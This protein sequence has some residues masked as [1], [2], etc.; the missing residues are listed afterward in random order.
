MQKGNPNYVRCYT[1]IRTLGKETI[2]KKK[3]KTETAHKKRVVTIN[4]G[5]FQIGEMVLKP[6]Q[7]TKPGR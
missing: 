2:E 3:N 5:I 4:E 1:N 6:R 7:L